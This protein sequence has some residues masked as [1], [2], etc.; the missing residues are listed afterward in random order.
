MVRT[1]NGLPTTGVEA[2]LLRL[3]HLLDAES[4]E[5]ACEDAR[6]RRLTSIPALHRYLERYAKRGRP[7]VTA[8]RRLL[9][10][11]RTATI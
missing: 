10:E 5:I 2:T 1:V 4:F 9:H 11:L 7:G 8:L 6:R 3:A